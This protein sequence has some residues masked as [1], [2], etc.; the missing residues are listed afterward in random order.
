MTA[1]KAPRSFIVGAEHAGERLDRFLAIA[2]PGMSRRF[3]KRYFEARLVKL[4]DQIGRENSI[5][6]AGDRIEILE[7]LKRADVRPELVFKVGGPFK[8]ISILFEDESILVVSKDR[9]MPSVVHEY[10]DEVT[11]ADCIAAYCPDCRSA[12]PDVREAGLVQRLDYYTT[13]VMIAAKNRK[14]WERLRATLFEEQVE[15]YYEALVEGEFEPVFANINW[16]LRQTNDGKRMEAALKSKRGK[17]AVLE[18]RSRIERVGVFTTEFG[19]TVSLVRCAIA[20]ARRHQVRAHL[21]IAGYPLVGDELYGSTTK[22]E[23]MKLGGKRVFFPPLEGFFLHASEVAFTHPKHK[24][25]VR[26]RAA[27]ETVK[28]LRAFLENA[29]ASDEVSARGAKY[30]KDRTKN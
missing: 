25:E 5:L 6:N 16:P 26:V 2:I 12:S 9:A 21:S 18:A 17:S 1:D 23:P 3:A 28:A 22:L 10:D 27:N 8:F 13:G 7:E 15:K 24:G 4:N 11:V 30:P 29:E 14:T 19:R 20:R